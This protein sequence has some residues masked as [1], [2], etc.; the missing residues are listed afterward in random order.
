MRKVVDFIKLSNGNL[1]IV[2]RPDGR[3]EI[4]ELAEKTEARG[5]INDA[6]C[7]AFDYQ[8]CNGWEWIDPAEV[9][10]LTD[11]LILTDDADRD[12]HGKLVACGRV[13]SNIDR[14]QVDNDLVVLRDRGEVIWSGCGLDQEE[15][16]I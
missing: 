8:L 12:D 4:A 2:V 3:E 15:E 14:Y 10:A 16:V 11:A 5:G 1:R 7:E 9:G 6:V 13:Y